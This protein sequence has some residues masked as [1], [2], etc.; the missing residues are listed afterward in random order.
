M[1]SVHSHHKL[2]G[3][4]LLTSLCSPQ[5]NPLYISGRETAKAVVMY[6]M[7]VGIII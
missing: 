6:Q 4:T 2:N 1:H 5:N 7:T 3:A